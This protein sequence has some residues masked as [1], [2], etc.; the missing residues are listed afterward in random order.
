MA[1]T[2]LDTTRVATAGAM[3]E[4]AGA[5]VAATALSAAAEEHHAL[6]AA[7]A[8]T[9]TAAEFVHSGG[10][11]CWRCWQACSSVSA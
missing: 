10:V 7:E 9:L 3:L 1:A 5:A 4:A 6:A 8:V 11:G 2:G